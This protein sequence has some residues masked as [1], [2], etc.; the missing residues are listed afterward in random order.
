MTNLGAFRHGSSSER[1]SNCIGSSEEVP[2]EW[3]VLEQ[4]SDHF[5]SD[6]FVRM[7]PRVLLPR[8]LRPIPRVLRPLPQRAIPQLLRLPGLVR[9]IP[10][11]ARPRR[12]RAPGPCH[13]RVTGPRHGSGPRLLR[14]RFLTGRTSGHGPRRL[15]RPRHLR[16]R[17]LRLGVRLSAKLSWTDSPPHQSFLFC[18]LF[19]LCSLLDCCFCWLIVFGIVGGILSSQVLEGLAYRGHALSTVFTRMSIRMLSCRAPCGQVSAACCQAC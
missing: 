13:G 12:G 5:V 11:L 16:P 8:V 17:L 19:R 14:P 15:Q 18:W 1:F 6:S 2:A 7:L 10:G 9:A 4:F 3:Q